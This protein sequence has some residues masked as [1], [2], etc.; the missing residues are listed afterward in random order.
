M[1]ELLT[2]NHLD[3]ILDLF[4]GVERDVNIISPFLTMSM[5][6]KLC[7]VKE[8]K[9]LA[10]TFITRLYLED[11]FA[12]ANSLDALELMLDKGVTV[13]AV[14][15]LHTKLYLFDDV[16]A[17]IGSANFTTGGF[18][19]NIE[20]SLLL[21]NEKD[22][23]NEAQNYFN[24]M[25]TAIQ[26]AEDGIVTKELLSEARKRYTMA[27]EARKHAQ[28]QDKAN[29]NRV[30][31]GAILNKKDKN[32][33]DKKDW[34]DDELA[35]CAKEKDKMYDLF[36]PLDRAEQV[37]YPYTIWLKFDGSGNDRIAGDGVFPMVLIEQN[38]KKRYLAN[39]PFK[40]H[41]VK[42]GDEVYLAA[43]STDSHGKN[44]PMI[45]G[46][47]HL[48]GFTDE[49]QVTDAMIHKYPWMVR[50]PWY[51]VIT[52]CE[53]LDTAVSNGLPMDSVWDKLGSDTYVASF[54]RNED[55]AAVARK[56]HKKAHIRLSGN[57]K[58]YIDKELD[59]LK[60]QYGAVEYRSE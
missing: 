30:M 26:K 20:L 59:V 21:S 36:K 49:N 47:G 55:I 22:V 33:P 41:S 50:Y 52:D 28:S 9:N 23:I 7:E 27:F 29:Y 12:K 37:K 31:Y 38:G 5:A 6:E 34:R 4:D 54:G 19:S 11:M 35:I 44:Q 14:K 32:Y 24:R 40:V 25:I 8:K 43:I 53:V 57:A 2:D 17:I 51:C 48:A 56:H 18:K 13:Y 45:V 42:D 39:Y 60:Q 15:R 58:N 10:C 46:R 1:I 3:K 16:N